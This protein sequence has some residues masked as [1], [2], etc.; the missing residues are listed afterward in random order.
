MAEKLSYELLQR[1][2]IHCP[3]VPVE[4]IMLSDEEQP[5]EVRLVP[6]TTHRGAILLFATPIAVIV[7]F[8]TVIGVLVG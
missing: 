6:L 8:I 5:I 2:G 1:V 3:P 7:S 4:T